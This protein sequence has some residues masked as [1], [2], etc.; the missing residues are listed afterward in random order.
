MLLVFVGQM[1][2]VV[3]LFVWSDLF[4]SWLNRILVVSVIL[5]PPL[6]YLTAL[7]RPSMRHAWRD[8]LLDSWV[9]IVFVVKEFARLFRPATVMKLVRFVVSLK[10][11]PATA[12]EWITCC[13]LPFKTCIVATF[14]MIWIFEKIVAHSPYFR[15]Y[16]RVFGLSYNLIFECYLAS[17]LALLL[18][19]LLQAIFCH[20]ERATTTL[21][22][23]LLGFVL[24]FIS[25]LIPWAI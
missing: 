1:L 5:L 13:V 21:R 8:L 16:G 18:G 14:P 17:L 23:F 20:A 9:T 12:D 22:F 4:P 24:L 2:L 15:P 11:M 19:A 10:P 7:A 3:A 6:V 25:S